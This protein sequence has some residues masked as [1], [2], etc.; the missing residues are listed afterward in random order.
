MLLIFLLF[1]FATAWFDFRSVQSVRATGRLLCAGLPAK[2]VSVRL[3]DD[4]F[5][6]K[7]T[8]QLGRTNHEGVFEVEGIDEEISWIDPYLD[9][10]HQ[11]EIDNVEEKR[12]CTRTATIG[13]PS[14]FITPLPIPEKTFQLGDF[15]LRNL[16]AGGQ[17]GKQ[18]SG[19]Y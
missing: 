16:Y 17:N 1:P 18:C 4:D 10:Y 8:M 3:Y 7:D 14:H 2:N 11:C 13:I 5:F 15:E 6:G 12:R 9:I 19:Y